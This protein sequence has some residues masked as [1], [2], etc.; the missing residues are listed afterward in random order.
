[1]SMS[2]W[3]MMRSLTARLVGGGPQ[4]GAGHGPRVV[5]YARP[6]K[7]QIIVFLVLVVVDAALVVAPP[8]LLAR[9]STTA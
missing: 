4:A 9:S 8:L 1:M 3:Q 6:Y 2:G 7:R 5:G